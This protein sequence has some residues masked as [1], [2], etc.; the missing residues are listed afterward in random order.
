VRCTS[1]LSWEEAS[2]ATRDAWERAHAQAIA[3]QLS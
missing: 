2:H 3:R 1:Q